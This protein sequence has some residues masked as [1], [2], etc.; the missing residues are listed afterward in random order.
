MVVQLLVLFVLESK[1]RSIYSSNIFGVFFPHIH[2]EGEKKEN[3]KP[4]GTFE[5]MHN[6]S[7]VF[8]ICSFI[9]SVRMR[10][11]EQL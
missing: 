8:Y 9:K 2:T 3:T 11:P 4:T 1:S 6:L 5:L 10:Y 7:S